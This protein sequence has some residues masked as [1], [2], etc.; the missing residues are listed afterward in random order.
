MGYTTEFEGK[1]E[2][3]PALPLDLI[4]Y[5]NKFSETRRMKRNTKVLKNIYNGEFGFNG[6][7]GVEGE[8]F[9]GDDNCS[10]VDYNDPPKTQPGLW[11]DWEIT[12]DGKCI[13]WNETEKFYDAE[14]WMQYIIDNFIGNDYS[15]NGTISAQGEEFDDQWDLIVENNKVRVER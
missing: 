4:E 1:I 10:I 6:D 12:K 15:C 9:I 2:I 11:C 8:Y 3:T 7:Y 5:I 13:Q 14:I